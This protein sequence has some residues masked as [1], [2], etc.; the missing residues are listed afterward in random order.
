MTRPRAGGAAPRHR[1]VPGRR[2]TIPARAGSRRCAILARS[3]PGDHPRTRGE[4]VN[5]LT[6]QRSTGGP[7]PH[8]RGAG[9][10]AR[11]AAVHVGTIPARAGSSLAEL[12]F[13]RRGGA[14]S[15]TSAWDVGFLPVQITLQEMDWDDPVGKRLR[16]EQERETVERYGGDIELGPK[17]SGRDVSTF[18]LAADGRSSEPVGCG[19]LRRLDAEAFEVKRMYVVPEWRGRRIGQVLPR[20]LERYAVD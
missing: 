16:D 14:F 11:R 10:T 2:G 18:L 4:Q 6:D 20:A 8:A 7:S 13:F 19:A 17:P 5:A 12:G 15:T 9:Q 3:S 1:L